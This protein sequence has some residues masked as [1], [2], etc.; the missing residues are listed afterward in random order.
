MDFK[1]EDLV[2]LEEAT[3]EIAKK[4]IVPSIILD[5]KGKPLM[6]M[7]TGGRFDNFFFWDT[8]FTAIWGRYFVES[9]A[10]ENCLDNLFAA[11]TEDGF[12]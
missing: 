11:R 12:I 7:G 9:L 6:R 4:K 1:P 2:D 8:A 10:I 3:L 5:S